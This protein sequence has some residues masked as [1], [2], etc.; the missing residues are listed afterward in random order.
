[1][2]SVICLYLTFPENIAQLILQSLTAA[3]SI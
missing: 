2:D 3:N 1:M